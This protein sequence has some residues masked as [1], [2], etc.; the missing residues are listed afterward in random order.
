MTWSSPTSILDY[1][2][3]F[4]IIKDH[5]S[6][7]SIKHQH[8]LS[9]IPH[10]NLLLI[11]HCPSSSIINRLPSI[12]ATTI[13]P[14]VK[15][16]EPRCVWLPQVMQAGGGWGKLLEDRPPSA[17][18]LEAQ[19]FVRERLEKKWLPLF[20]A[21][22]S[23]IERQKPKTRVDDVVDDVLIQKRRRSMAVWKVRSLY[24]RSLFV[25]NLVIFFFFK[26]FSERY[27]S[28]VVVYYQNINKREN[29][30]VHLLYTC[31]TAGGRLDSLTVAMT[32]WYVNM[33]ICANVNI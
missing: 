32:T 30:C 28:N 29:L 5:L 18:L 13:T 11:I 15:R 8:C 31:L 3:S 19:K 9:S 17:V 2:S 16:F 20:L 25:F 22:D 12:T 27:A 26:I 23:F 21:I 10:H 14:S 24:L 7:N 6:S 4:S 1:I 33:Q